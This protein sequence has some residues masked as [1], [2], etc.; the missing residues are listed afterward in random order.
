MNVHHAILRSFVDRGFAP[1][2]AELSQQLGRDAAPELRA[3]AGE[4]GVVLHP[5]DSIWIA[6]PFS[7]S[8]TATW[9]E[10][11]RPDAPA[12][13]WAPC[14][15]CALGIVALAGDDLVIC[16]R[17]AGES[18]EAVFTVSPD[19]VMPPVHVHFP[20]AARDAW[21][22]VVHWCASVLP[23]RDPAGVDDWCE[24]HR[25]ARGAVVPIDQVLALARAWYANHLAAD[26]RKHT[27]AEA[28]A[29]FAKVGLVGPHWALDG[30]GRY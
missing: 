13:W 1:T 6:H 8:P 30:D 20:I 11:H 14:L 10:C 16:A 24:R 29:I 18:S 15:W 27:V 22:N 17:Y 23:F 5:D 2:I 21:T 4:H 12:G 3:L 9:V 28:A 26:W 19:R 25:I 7:A